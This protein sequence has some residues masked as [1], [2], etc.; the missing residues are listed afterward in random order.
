M[1]AGATP[2]GDGGATPPGDGGA[3]PIIVAFIRGF[4]ATAG[5]GAA[6]GAGVDCRGA[7]GSAP[8]GA[9]GGRG[10]IGGAFTISIV[11]LNLGAAAPFRLKAHF[12]HACALSSFCVPQFGQNTLRYLRWRPSNSTE[13]HARIHALS[14]RPQVQ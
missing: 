14:A 8:A 9:A 4:W 3:T 2:A 5:R 6:A 7:E 11:P 10:A 12:W 1:G 13:R